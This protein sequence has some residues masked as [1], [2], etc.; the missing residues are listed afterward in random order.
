M[1]SPAWPAFPLVRLLLPFKGMKR[2]NLYSG[3]LVSL[4][5]GLAGCGADIDTG[6]TGQSIVETPESL[7]G[8]RGHASSAVPASG[9]YFLTTFGAS[10]GDDGRMSCGDFTR[11]GSWYYAA[12][13]QRYG[14]GSHIRIEANGRC[15]VARTDDYGP[16]VCVE[17]AAGGPIIDASPLVARHLFG[18]SSAGWSDHLHI[19]VHK[20]SSSTPLGPCH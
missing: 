1:I 19:T 16:D 8:C 3:I 7:H 9:H 4:A 12:S 17:N 15:V 18:T 2:H 5:L 6:D 10:P 20:V 14:C 13:R 11:H